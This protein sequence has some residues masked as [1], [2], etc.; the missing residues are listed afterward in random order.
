MK[1][2]TFTIDPQGHVQIVPE[3]Y[4]GETCKDATKAFEKALGVKS[5]DIPLPEM[6]QET[7]T[8]NINFNQW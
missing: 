5:S 1:S 4:L 6:Y 2:L 7:K 8:D 3:G